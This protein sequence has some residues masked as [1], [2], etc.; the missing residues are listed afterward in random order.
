PGRPG[1]GHATIGASIGPALD[2]YWQARSDRLRP[3]AAGGTL[4]VDVERIER[5]ACRHEQ[6]VAVDPARADVGGAVGQRDAADWLAVG[7]EYRDAVEFSRPH[8]PAAPQVAVDVT[9]HAVGRTRAGVDVHAFV[10]ELAPAVDHIVGQDLA[11]GHAAALDEVEDFLVGR[12]GEPLGP[13][14][15]FRENGSLQRVWL[16]PVDVGLDLR[17]RLIALVVTEDAERGIGEPDR[18]IRLH[19]HV[20]G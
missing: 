13:E 8:S 16:Q 9:T 3:S 15:A 18:A 10:G 14:H 17:L 2:R 4:R 20:V 1:A 7:R 19:H 6:A 12:E 11:V 5:L